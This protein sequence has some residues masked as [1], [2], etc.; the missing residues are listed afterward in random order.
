[1]SRKLVL[2]LTAVAALV[3]IAA[4]CAKTAPPQDVAA[5]KTKL[6]ADALSWFDHFA[7]A[8]SEG[9]A[10]LYAEDAVVLPPN[11]PA[12][13]GRAAIKTYLGSM[14]SGVKAGGMSIKNGTVT[15]SDVSGDMG[16]LS[17]TYSLQDSTGATIDSGKYLSV[18][19]R[20]NGT[21]LYVRDT[22]NSDMPAA[23]MAPPK[24]A[25]KGKK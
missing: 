3:V 17:G 7:S 21:W 12:V 1:M 13:N 24:S 22:W 25:K 5:D 15:G 2:A 19:H 4:G 14:A 8:D 9:M 11:A 10:N 6:Q 18:H 20:E 23:P 16:W